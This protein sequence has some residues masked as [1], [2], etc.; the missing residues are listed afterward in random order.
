MEYPAHMEIEGEG[1]DMTTLCHCKQK[2]V[3]DLKELP[4][5]E[6]EISYKTDTT[7]VGKLAMFGDR[8]MRAR[9]KETEKEF[10]QNLQKKLAS[11]A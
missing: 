5:G 8:I 9:A 7:I 10:T 2:T 3:M 4:G 6:V 1:E 11:L